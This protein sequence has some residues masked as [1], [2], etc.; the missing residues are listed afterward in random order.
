MDK[1]LQ[2][3]QA[4]NWP[5]VAALTTAFGFIGGMLIWLLNKVFKFGKISQRLT[6]LEK[7]VDEDIK[8]DIKQIGKRVDEVFKLI[9]ANSV[10]IARSPRQLNDSG[11]KILAQSGIKKIVDTHEAEIVDTVKSKHPK[12]AYHAEQEVV[13]AVLELCK[14]KD[15]RATIEQGA[16]NTG[17]MPQVVT[18]V[19]AI[20]IRDKVFRKIGMKVQDI[21]NHKPE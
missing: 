14:D 10:T 2:T 19:G 11:L 18:Y 15:I 20:Y 3:L 7:S 5:T 16:Y 17:S 9:A 4:I 13:N 1:I 6:S 12:N 21:D 8:P